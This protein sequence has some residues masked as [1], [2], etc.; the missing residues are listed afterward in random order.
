MWFGMSFFERNES[1]KSVIKQLEDSFEKLKKEKPQMDTDRHRLKKNRGIL[2]I[3]EFVGVHNP[4]LS[5]F[6]CIHLWF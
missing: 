1:F 3:G 5:A 2:P 6:I 4:S